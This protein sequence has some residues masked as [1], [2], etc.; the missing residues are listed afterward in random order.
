MPL[1]CLSVDSVRF[2]LVLIFS[3][4]AFVSLED[5][6]L[7]MIYMCFP[8]HLLNKKVPEL[9]FTV[10]CT[11]W[12]RKF[13]YL[14]VFA[15]NKKSVVAHGDR[16]QWWQMEGMQGNWNRTQ[17]QW[18]QSF[19]VFVCFWRTGWRLSVKNSCKST[20]SLHKKSLDTIV[21]EEGSS[22]S[23]SR[24]TVYIIT[25]DGPAATLCNWLQLS[26]WLCEMR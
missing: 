9:L 21:C 10:N 24:N 19:F 13:L 14:E 5:L 16:L 22:D 8:R 25:M 23:I 7:S 18:E 20:H 15:Q 26:P 2:I 17:A 6:L 4:F 3:K 11:T 1:L 12:E